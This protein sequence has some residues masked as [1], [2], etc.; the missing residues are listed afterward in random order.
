MKIVIAQF[1]HETNTFSPVP[2]PLERFGGGA[3]P[4]EGAAVLDAYRG[5][6]SAIAAFIDLA[7]RLGAAIDT[8][9]AASAAPS[10]PCDDAVFDDV[11]GRICDAV[12]RGCDAVLLDL[13]GAMVTA[14]HDDGE[15]EL[16]RRI[17]TVAPGVM[18]GVALDMHTN[19]SATMVENASVIAGY[20][21]YPHIDMYETG[22]RAAKPILASLQGC[23]LPT[24][25]WGSR[26]MLTHVMRQG[27]DDE[28]N[29]S[30]QAR[31]R[32]LEAEGVLG[33][34]V[35][36]GFPHADIPIVSLSA[37]VVDHDPARARAAC[38]ELLDMAWARREGFVYRLEALENSLARARDLADSAPGSGPIVLLDHFDNCASGGTMDT[39]T[40]LKAVIASGLEDVA[41]FAIYDPQAARRMHE[42]GIGARLTLSLGGKLPMPSIGRDGE[43]LT[44]TGEVR[45]LSDGRFRN[46]GPMG[47]GQQVNMGP[48]GVLRVG[49]VDIAVISEHV[50]PHDVAAFEALGIDPASRRFLMLKSRVHWRAGLRQYARAVVECAG[51]GVCTSDYGS[52]TYHKLARP[53][54]P[55]DPLASA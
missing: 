9:I 44:V 20:Q 51:T 37:V 19:L 35:F 52:L 13:H 4:P 26:P 43:P 31:A 41:A 22:V 36:T 25:V 15:G 30:L 3:R 54:Y 12:A 33:A 50:E 45:A 8:P 46:H 5:T 21:T 10:A 17:R 49:G 42:A 1:K 39:T 55:L 29:R 47:R 23:P 40:V 2:T 7:E 11:S 18:I 38:D 34:T 14:S 16:L 27:T 24:M 53:I 32:E 6:G 48:S 28:P